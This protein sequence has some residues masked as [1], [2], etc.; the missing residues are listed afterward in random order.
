MYNVGNSSD[1]MQPKRILSVKGIPFV[2]YKVKGNYVTISIG[3]CSEPYLITYRATEL[4]C[5]SNPN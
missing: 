3:F 5:L 2:S 1:K 4:H